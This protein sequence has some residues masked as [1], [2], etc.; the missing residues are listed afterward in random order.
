[1]GYRKREYIANEGI[2]KQNLVCYTWFM[3]N[4]IEFNTALDQLGYTAER[5]AELF[6]VKSVTTVQNWRSGIIPAPGWAVAMTEYLLARPEARVW[7]EERRPHF[8]RDTKRR[9]EKRRKVRA[10]DVA[11]TPA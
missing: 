5:F 8:G 9:V 4:E 7:F 1:M 2:A 6:D 3:E 10:K 11:A